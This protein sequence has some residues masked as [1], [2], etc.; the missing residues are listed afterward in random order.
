MKI[1]LVSCVAAVLLALV[2]A[3]PTPDVEKPKEETAP[4][5][6]I[7]SRS[8]RSH[9]GQPGGG[10]HPVQYAPQCAAS[11]P[12][13]YSLNVGPSL[14]GGAAGYGLGPSLH[15]PAAG[16]GLSPL[17]GHGGI[18]YGGYGL[19]RYRSEDFD[20]QDAFDMEGSDHIP[21]MRSY[22]GYE[23]AGPGLHIGHAGLGGLAVGGFGAPAAPAGPAY[24]VF[25]SS[26]KACDVPLLLSCAPS[27]VPGRLVSHHYG[28]GAAAPAYRGSEHE[29]KEAHPEEHH[30]EATAADQHNAVTQENKKTLN[31]ATHH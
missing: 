14:H 19:H 2:Q 11:A 20:E 12:V 13:P 29:M 1:T 5:E 30:M 31:T 8:K 15:G 18:G 16:Y 27:I 26:G 9:Y 17:S 28:P 22:G 25:P 21:M 24:G 10:Y 3:A 4:V 7:V 23:S 6:E